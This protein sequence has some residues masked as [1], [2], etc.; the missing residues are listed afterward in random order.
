MVARHLRRR[1]SR[2]PIVGHN[3]PFNEEAVEQLM[4]PAQPLHS[5]FC[6]SCVILE[7]R[8]H[9][10]LPGSSLVKSIFRLKHIFYSRNNYTFLEGNN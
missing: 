5:V 4:M 3:A 2:K 6:L 10:L 7:R 9:L 8:A 1:T